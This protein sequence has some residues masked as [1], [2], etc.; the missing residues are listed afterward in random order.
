MGVRARL[1]GQKRVPLPPA[2]S[3]VWNAPARTS[4][5]LDRPPQS[6]RERHFRSEAEPLARGVDRGARVADVPGPRG[7]ALGHELAARQLGDRSEQLVQLVWLAAG[8]V[9]RRVR[10]AAG[11]AVQ[12]SRF[13][14][15]TLATNV[16]SRVC[17]PS[18]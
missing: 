2:R 13:A 4:V 15:T 17:S 16:K 5:G 6:L 8:D 3:T 1:S 10:S 11:P 14:C 12:A 9:V 18:P 7:D